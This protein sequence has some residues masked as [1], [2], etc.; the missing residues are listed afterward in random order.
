MAKKVVLKKVGHPAEFAS[1]EVLKKYYKKLSTQEVE[2][3]V[4]ELSL[5]FNAST[6]ASIHRMRACMAVLYHFFPKQVSVKA[7][8]KYAEYSTEEL[9]TIAADSNIPVEVCDDMRILRMRTIMALRAHK[10]I[11]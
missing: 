6:D 9:I 11:S 8:S 1:Q 2:A 5:S 7:K 4:S 3:W 10:V